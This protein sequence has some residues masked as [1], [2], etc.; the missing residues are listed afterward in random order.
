VM[1]EYQRPQQ[2]RSRI[3][4]TLLIAIGCFLLAAQFL[5]TRLV[6]LL[7]LPLLGFIFLAWGTVGANKAMAIP[8]GILLGIGTGVIM[9]EEVFWYLGQPASTGVFLVCFA[10]GWLVAYI[11]SYKTGGRKTSWLLV[12][13][14]VLAAVGIPLI[15]AQTAPEIVE[16]IATYWPALLIAAGI[17][18]I[19]RGVK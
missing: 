8:G 11:V 9:S 6:S 1:T 4:G 13:G 15:L 2:K 14:V 7:V 18:L 5:D 10:L 16:W 19:V 12:L 3:V 17:M